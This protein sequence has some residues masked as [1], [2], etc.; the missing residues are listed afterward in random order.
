MAAPRKDKDQKPFGSSRHVIH[1]TGCYHSLLLLF[2]FRGQST[3]AA[4]PRLGLLGPAVGRG[5][6]WSGA[7]A[8]GEGD[9]V[10]SSDGCYGRTTGRES[11][12]AAAGGD[13]QSSLQLPSPSPASSLGEEVGASPIWP[14]RTAS[15]Q[16]PASSFCS[17]REHPRAAVRTD[18]LHSVARRLGTSS[19]R[20]ACSPHLLS[21]HDGCTID[22]GRCNLEH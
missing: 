15:R 9:L 19:I 7:A 14:Q 20:P 21:Y 12:D 1:H 5:T 17:V 4:V 6:L 18:M 16:T 8:T 3:R 13:A 2:G 10:G 11:G 22:V